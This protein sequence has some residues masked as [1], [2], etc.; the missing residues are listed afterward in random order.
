MPHRD[1]EVLGADRACIWIDEGVNVVSDLEEYERALSSALREPAGER[2]AA[3]LAAALDRDGELLPEELY[4]DWTLPARRR[5]ERE[6]LEARREHARELDA[7]LASVEA[8]RLAWG[9]VLVELPGDGEAMAARVAIELSEQ[10]P[11]RLVV[12]GAGPGT[13]RD[14]ELARLRQAVVTQADGGHVLVTGAAGIGKTF[15]LEQL[16]LALEAEGWT[17]LVGCAVDGDREVPFAALRA[18]L[19]PLR[20]AILEGSRLANALAQGG[21]RSRAD[22]EATE[23]A[24]AQLAEE[25][26][27]LLDAASLTAPLALVL[28]D[29]QWMDE[30]LV[31]LLARLTARRGRRW[32]VVI[33]AR[34]EPASPAPSMPM[35][36][37]ELQPLRRSATEHLVRNLLGEHVSSRLATDLARRSGGNPFY[38]TELARAS[39]NDEGGGLPGE[40][41]IPAS[42]VALLRQRLERTSAPARALCEL[43]ALLGENATYELVLAT[44]ANDR[45]LGSSEA[46]SGGAR[47]LLDQVLLAERAG[48][49]R[50]A[51]PLVREAIIASTPAL[52]RSRWHGLIADTCEKAGLPSA[53]ALHRLAAFEGVRTSETAAAAAR[54][55]LRAA[56]E[57]R[58]VYA[59]GAAANLLERSL[60]AIDS[61][62][63]DVREELRAVEL[64]ARL[65]L[66]AILAER[67]R[68]E[69]AAAQFDRALPLARGDDETSRAWCE[70]AGIPYRRGDIDTA[71]ATYEAG[72]EQLEASE[73]LAR[74]L[75]LSDLAWARYRREGPLPAIPDLRTTAQ[76]F[77][78]AGDDRA[79]SRGFDRLAT[80]LGR[81]GSV[82]EALESSDIAFACCARAPDE[83]ERGIL[84]LHRAAIFYEAGRSEEGLAET[85]RAA[86]G[87]R[88]SIYLRSVL[89]WIEADLYEQCGHLAEALSASDREV[90]LLS[91]LDNRRNAALA[92]ARRARLLA[93]LG[94]LR[95]GDEAKQ[96]ALTAA[97]S[98]NDPLLTARVEGLIA[99]KSSGIAPS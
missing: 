93:A 86:R 55:G 10:Q 54:A 76:A 50:V 56:L 1:Y 52:E 68:L 48:G 18:A 67:G 42:I 14:L 23:S 37:I 31:R 26:G 71:I 17:V 4:S 9:R 49:L 91:K 57:A 94:Q 35:V 59:N 24:F 34:D 85:E 3:A 7:A 60:S 36:R 41:T 28:D 89:A 61:A 58:G 22:G 29:A 97:A 98:V 47:E 65:A 45:S 69:A 80:A 40:R 21:S 6:R 32:A 84:H 82:E 90:D 99:G 44:A 96:L 39:L 83:R 13:G 53:V 51:H 66:G 78:A 88:G 77:L 73:G 43:V 74:A 87:L 5:L 20:G 19:S 27:E 15:M 38:A 16:R 70:I 2:R 72:L 12:A 11:P 75:L 79:A 33:G 95:D 46:V 62:A 25:V 30:D 63:T 81:A 92:Q 8:R 64:E